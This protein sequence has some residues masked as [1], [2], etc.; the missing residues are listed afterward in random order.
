[1]LPLP[2]ILYISAEAVCITAPILVD[3][4]SLPGVYDGVRYKTKSVLAGGS[5][6]DSIRGFVPVNQQTSSLFSWATLTVVC[7][8]SGGPSV[9]LV[10]AVLNTPI[11]RGFVRISHQSRTLHMQ[12]KNRPGGTCK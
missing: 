6:R 8:C 10:G 1:M 5:P 3:A 2:S 4:A 12:K 11:Q 7:R 9:S